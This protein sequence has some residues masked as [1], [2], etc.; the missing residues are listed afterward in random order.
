MTFG[1]ANGAP[2]EFGVI[3]GL[4]LA[5]LYVGISLRGNINT[6]WIDAAMPRRARVANQAF[7]GHRRQALPL[8]GRE[9]QISSLKVKDFAHVIKYSASGTTAK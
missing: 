4:N 7:P 6:L 2:K 5:K 8:R 3:N 1:N 9:R